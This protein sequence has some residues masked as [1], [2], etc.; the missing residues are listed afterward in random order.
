MTHVY[1]VTSEPG[2]MTGR[3]D[4]LHD[5]EGVAATLERALQ[6]I[7][8]DNAK[9]YKNRYHVSGIFLDSQ[10]EDGVYRIFARLKHS[11]L[12]HSELEDELDYVIRRYEVLE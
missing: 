12:G 4:C 3:D 7:H 1:V 2:D 10:G 8:D 11:L 9:S 5:V 6:V